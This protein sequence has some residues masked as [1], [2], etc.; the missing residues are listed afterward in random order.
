LEGWIGEILAMNIL[1]VAF[2]KGGALAD[3]ISQL[4]NAISVTDS[5]TVMAP[6]YVEGVKLPGGV[7]VARFPFPSNLFG[8][9]LQGFNPLLL[10]SLIYKVNHINP[11]VIHMAFE[12]RLPFTF[13][14]LLHREYPVVLTIHEPKPLAV[15]AARAFLLNHIQLMD[16]KLL[17]KSADKVIVHGEAHKKYLLARRVSGYKV[18]IVPHGDFSFYTRYRRGDIKISESSNILFF[19]R[20]ASYKGL[21]YL[22]KA[23]KLINE[24]IPNATITIAGEGEFGKYERLIGHDENFI[25][26]NRF[27]PNEEVAELFRKASVVV[28]PYIAGTQSGIITIAGAF[29]KPVVATDVGNFSEM[30]ENG[31]T[32]FL[33][34]ARDVNALAEAIIKLLKDDKLRWEMGE[35][36]YKIVK[37]KFSWDK[38]A[39]K[40]LEVYEEAIEAWE[41]N[42][43]KR[44]AG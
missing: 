28:L 16:N 37:E 9:M 40:T 33:V 32:G 42:S 17:L 12:P 1:I 26:L 2:A 36:A 31:R 14:R 24:Q 38:I 35:N 34:P 29:K 3:Y 10:R 39:Q 8:A 15:E 41:R 18:E 13:V 20:V 6:D 19:G 4:S 22:I 30:V 7:K 11:D 25:I 27:I 23:G 43:S 44:N 5:V 21:D